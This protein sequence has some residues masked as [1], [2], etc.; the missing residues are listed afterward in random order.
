MVKLAIVSS[1][2]YLKT[3]QAVDFL[4]YLDN[5]KISYDKLK[6]EDKSYEN[7]SK[8][9]FNLIIIMVALLAGIVIVQC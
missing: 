6:L 1:K 4:Q 9:T 3:K 2:K 7:T 8:N 5:Q